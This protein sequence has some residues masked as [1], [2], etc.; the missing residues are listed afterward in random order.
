MVQ[1]IDTGGSVAG[2]IGKG[3]G[4]GLAEQIPKDV[5]RYLLS[6]GLQKLASSTET[7]PMKQLASLYSIPG[8]TP[9]IAN[10]AQEYLRGQASIN[11]AK[12]EEERNKAKPPISAE[13]QPTDANVQR[14]VSSVQPTGKQPSPS[15]LQGT[16][17]AIRAGGLEYTKKYP[18]RYRNIASAEERY[19]EDLANQNKQIQHINDRFKTVGEQLLQKYGK[20]TYQSVLGELQRDFERKAEDAVLSGKMSETE[21]ADHYTTKMLDFA[22]ARNKLQTKGPDK[23]KA[24]FGNGKEELKAAKKAYDD[25]DKP[26]AFLN[27]LVTYQKLSL[28]RASELAFPLSKDESEYLKSLKVSAG[29]GFGDQGKVYQQALDRLSEEDSL[30]NVALQLYKK[31][32]SP[33]DFLKYVQNSGKEL[34]PFQER[35]LQSIGS[36]Q[37]SLSDI[38]Y[39]TL[40]GKGE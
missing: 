18:N 15:R 25:A 36:F 30:Q 12:A 8:I 20:E 13:A 32:Y 21:A 34:T 16:P 14:S 38:L 26:E 2:R 29:K 31:S 39:F 17:E 23:W 28:P 24:V 6:S 22:K 10:Q 27:D 1:V 35:E 9:E 37:P 19:R 33:Q 4:K 40:I 5:N 7:N 11:E 3:F